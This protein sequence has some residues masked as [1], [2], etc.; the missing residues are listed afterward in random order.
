MTELYTPK[1]AR[2][3]LGG[4]SSQE[5]RRLVKKGLIHTVRPLKR[6]FDYYVKEDVDRIAAD[7]EEFNQKYKIVRDN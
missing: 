3:R 2:E 4:I 7:W 1:E 5:L 6:D